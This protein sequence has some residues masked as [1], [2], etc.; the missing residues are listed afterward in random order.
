MTI[1]RGRPT[2]AEIDLAALRANYRALRAFTNG[3]DLMAVVKADAYG[4]GAVEVARVLHDEGCGHFGV[5]TVEEARELRDAGLISR[6]YLLGGFFAEQAEDVV[7]LDLTP[8]ICDV[9]L[10]DPLNKAAHSLERHDFPVRL[11]GACTLLANAAD[12]SSPV[13]DHQLAHFRGALAALN[14]A[15]FDLP[16]NHVA[17]SAATVLRSDAHFNL[18]RPGLAIYGL[19]PVPAVRDQVGL[20]PVMTFKT[21]V[22]Q[23][24][25]VPPGSG[26]SYG[27][28]Y[29]TP[30][31]SLIGV[32]AVGYAD[33]YRRSFQQ[34]GEV[35]VRGRRAPVVGAVCMDL[36]MVD[37]TDVP[38]ARIGDEA[39]LW[40]GAGEA[41][42]SVNDVAR[43]ARPISYEMLCTVGRRDPR[44][45]RGS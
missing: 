3:A 19:P 10:V 9:S 2:F 16:V 6:I 24:K 39:V 11:E 27:H 14:G 21:R 7:G 5:A 32:L 29:V 31:D 40:G 13:T 33:G 26:V 30:R 35:M 4:H 42:I 1:G 38:G 45:Y 37:L 41:M 18:M 25:R 43:L 28:T 12:P 22:M 34:G 23:V 20:R 36:T 44:V 17:N 15:G 8:S